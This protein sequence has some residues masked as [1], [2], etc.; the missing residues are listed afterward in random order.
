MITL[1]SCAE[2]EKGKIFVDYFMGEKFFEVVYA[3]GSY[4]GFE[5][6]TSALIAIN[7]NLNIPEPIE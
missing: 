7:A 2:T 4:Q 6:W 3:D 5:V 1:Q